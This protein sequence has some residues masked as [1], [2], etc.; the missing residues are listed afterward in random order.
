MRTFIINLKHSL[1][2]REKMESQLVKLNI[3]HEFIEAVDGREMTDAERKNVTREVNYAFLPGEVGCALS[4]QA[5]YKK[6]ITENIEAALILEDDIE[7]S[8]DLSE[9]LNN[10]TL[11]HTRP[12][13][14][15]LS[16]V[17]KYHK[18][19]IKNIYGSYNVHKVHH[20]TTA[21]AYIIN[22]KAASR[23]LQ[24][25][26]P[27]WMVSDKWSLFEDLS[28]AKIH[29]LVPYPV[30][31]SEEANDSTINESKGDALLDAKKKKIWNSLMQERPL[32]AK[33]R[34]RYRRAITPLFNKII[35]QGKG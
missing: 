15:L 29:A 14:L 17:N 33:L 26:Y 8:D 12:E 28:L 27:V 16:R 7:L 18:K 13:I 6:I 10:V 2:R 25:L 35:N 3:T 5:I 20:A 4:H 21:H 23:L 11:S 24:N 34:H 19:P 30:R 32:A 1:E 31:L 9:I 22:Q